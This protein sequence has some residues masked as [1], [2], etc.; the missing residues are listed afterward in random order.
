MKRPTV[1]QDAFDEFDALSNV[2]LKS[3]VEGL[4]PLCGSRLSP[5]PG[6]GCS[7]EDVARCPK[8]LVSYRIE[9][10]QFE[11]HVPAGCYLRIL[12]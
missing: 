8:H 12:T 11:A 10:R 2:Q 7:G 6:A 5:A 4:C 9:G 3:V 1:G